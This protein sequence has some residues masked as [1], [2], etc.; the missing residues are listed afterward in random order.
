VVENQYA[1]SVRAE[2]NAA[3]RTI[4]EDV[5][6]VI[7][8]NWRGIGSIPESGLGLS[9]AYAAFDA[10]Q[11]FDLQ[12]GAGI[13]NPD[14]ISGLIL[15]GIRK[16]EECDAFGTKCTPDTPL[17]ATMVSGEGACAAYYK[18]RKVDA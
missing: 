4:M 10:V 18:Y 2:G 3:A 16:P 8:R 13:E 15:Q 6:Q 9:E 17:G 5:F 14:C 11:R 12:G 1:R 7:P